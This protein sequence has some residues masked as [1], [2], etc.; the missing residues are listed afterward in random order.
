MVSRKPK[1]LNPKFG[2]FSANGK[3]AEDEEEEVASPQT[4]NSQRKKEQPQPK[5]KKQKEKEEKEKEHPAPTSAL[6]NAFDVVLGEDPD[7]NSR[8]TR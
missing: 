1:Y 5:R 4:S 7:D 8:R 6:L 2:H 3:K